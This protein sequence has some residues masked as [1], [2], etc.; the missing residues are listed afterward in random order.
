MQMIKNSN[1]NND[2]KKKDM[3]VTDTKV[4]FIKQSCSYE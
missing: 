4:N 3:K 1:N 2:F